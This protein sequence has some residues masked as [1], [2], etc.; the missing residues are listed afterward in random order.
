VWSLPKKT[1]TQG[2]SAKYVYDNFS[3]L[4]YSIPRWFIERNIRKG[5][6]HIWLGPKFGVLALDADAAKFVLKSDDLVKE[7]AGVKAVSENFGA[8]LVS[9]DGQDWRRQK[10][11]VQSGFGHK[12]YESYFPTFQKLTDKVLNL[13]IEDSK[14]GEEVYIAGWLQKFTLDILGQ[15]VFNY[16]FK[17]L[18]HENDETYEAYKYVFQTAAR[19]FRFLPFLQYLPFLEV[20][21]KMNKSIEILKTK[22]GKIIEN[23]RKLN[24]TDDILG[25]MLQSADDPVSGLS[26]KELISNVWIFFIAGHETTSTAL[27]WALYELSHRPEM[28]DRICN[29]VKSVMGDRTVITFEDLPKF[30]FL[31]RFIHETLRRRSPVGILPTRKAARDIQYGKQFIPKGTLVGLSID[32]IHMNPEYWPEPEKFDP[33]RFLPENK[34]GR[35]TFSFL[36][37]SLG[38]RQC[39]GNN[40][41][42]IEQRLFLATILTKLKVLPSKEQ[43]NPNLAIGFG[44]RPKKLNLKFVPRN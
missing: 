10:A 15:T 30:E 4:G 19:V 24:S 17:S 5:F 16:D 28:Q 21:K 18:D 42:L 12:A 22:F 20:T 41:S 27:Q 14:K 11:V 37:F 35:N 29:E 1:N 6:G 44:S 33:D 13:I 26:Y 39:I 8:H 7:V 3:T 23:H 34:K 9:V 31:D 32:S 40:F 2:P 36:P 43:F 38:Q 25:H